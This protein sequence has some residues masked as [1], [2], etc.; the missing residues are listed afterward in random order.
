MTHP[1]PVDDGAALQR[2][3]APVAWRDRTGA[4]DRDGAGWLRLL[5]AVLD[6]DPDEAAVTDALLDTVDL[7]GDLQ[8]LVDALADLLEYATSPGTRRAYATDWADFA[9]WTGRH[10]LAALARSWRPPGS[11]QQVSQ[12]NSWSPLWRRTRCQAVLCRVARVALGHARITTGAVRK[13]RGTQVRVLARF[14]A[15]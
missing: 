12:A 2:L 15:V 8:P 7:A 3:P 4:P 9:D 11:R 10:R 13:N 14:A 1:A 6:D 5:P